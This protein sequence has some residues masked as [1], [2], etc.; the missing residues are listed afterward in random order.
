MQVI[1]RRLCRFIAQLWREPSDDNIEVRRYLQVRLAL[2]FLVCVCYFFYFAGGGLR[3]LKLSLVPF[4]V[5]G[6]D[7]ESDNPKKNDETV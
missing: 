7:L 1:T 3:K 2:L 4:E 5:L 6:S